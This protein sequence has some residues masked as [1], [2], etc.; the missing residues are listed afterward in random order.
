MQWKNYQ[1][2]KILMVEL[3]RRHPMFEAKLCLCD[4]LVSTSIYTTNRFKM[5]GAKL[6]FY[7]FILADCS[8]YSC[9]SLCNIL[10]VYNIKWTVLDYILIAKQRSFLEHKE[11]MEEETVVIAWVLVMW[12]QDENFQFPRASYRFTHISHLGIIL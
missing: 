2:L 1:F 6:W 5:N 11:Y 3:C 4:F 9:G 8:E 7:T 12:N 10:L